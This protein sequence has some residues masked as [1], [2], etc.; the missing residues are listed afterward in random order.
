MAICV[1][2]GSP[3][4]WLVDDGRAAA[5]V[6]GDTVITRYNGGL[7][8]KAAEGGCVEPCVASAASGAA[9]VFGPLAG[10]D[11]LTADQRRTLV[12]RAIEV[13]VNLLGGPAD[14][15]RTMAYADAAN[16]ACAALLSQSG[17]KP[18]LDPNAP[19]SAHLRPR[20]RS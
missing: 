5:V 8:P 2:S 18:L 17:T 16:A 4:R 9:G 10:L 20:T 11:G 12:C 7:T 19:I 14:A 3:E 1:V 6:P 13:T 15:A